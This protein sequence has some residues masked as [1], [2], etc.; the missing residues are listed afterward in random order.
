MTSCDM[1]R[2]SIS[3]C[4]V[5]MQDIPPP[6]TNRCAACRRLHRECWCWSMAFPSSVLLRGDALYRGGQ[7]GHL[8]HWL[9]RRAVDGECQ[10]SSARRVVH[11][12]ELAVVRQHGVDRSAS[13]N[14]GSHSSRGVE[15][16]C[17]VDC[18]GQ[19]GSAPRIRNK[20]GPPTGGCESAGRRKRY[21]SA[22]TLRSCRFAAP[23]PQPT[24]YV[25]AC[26]K[27]RFP[28]TGKHLP[29]GGTEIHSKSAPSR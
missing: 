1:C 28:A 17:R 10:D 14:R 18:V 29:P 25:Y 2:A 26:Y 6:T 3:R 12:E 15:H 7:S 11:V 24:K 9:Q 20:R 5:R 21:S 27:T 13:G 4:S 16:A 23:L 22:K 19:K 8:R